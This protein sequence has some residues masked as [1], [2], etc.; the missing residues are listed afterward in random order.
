MFLIKFFLAWM[1]PDVPKDVL[2]RIKREKL[3][4]VKIL[5]DFE[6]NKL[7]ENLRLSSTSSDFDRHF[8]IKESKANLAESTT[9]LT[10]WTRVGCLSGFTVYLDL[11]PEAR[12]HVSFTLSSS[13]SFFFLTQ[14]FCT[15]LWRPLYSFMEVGRTALCFTGWTLP[16]YCFWD[17]INDC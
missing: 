16:R 1:I 10:Q 5:H 8:A 4:T 15:L 3:M 7:K 17:S 14:S 2:A 12:S 6:L 13:S 9:Y 11:E